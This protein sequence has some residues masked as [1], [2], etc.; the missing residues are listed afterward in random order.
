M[1]YLNSFVPDDLF[2]YFRPPVAVFISVYIVDHR[3]G[4][5]NTNNDMGHKNSEKEEPYDEME[6]TECKTIL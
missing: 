5:F 1:R 6:V 3:K 4:I 2:T